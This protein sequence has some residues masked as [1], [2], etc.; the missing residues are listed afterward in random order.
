MSGSEITSGVNPDKSKPIP[1]NK[2]TNIRFFVQDHNRKG[3]KDGW[4]G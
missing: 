4:V 1:A 3:E 2:G